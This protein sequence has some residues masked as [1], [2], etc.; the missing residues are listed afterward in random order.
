MSLF[1]TKPNTKTMPLQRNKAANQDLY[2]ARSPYKLELQLE[3]A[4]VDNDYDKLATSRNRSD[5]VSSPRQLSGEVQNYQIQLCELENE[6]G[7]L[8]DK[9]KELEMLVNENL[10]SMRDQE[11]QLAKKVLM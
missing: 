6:N 5:F 3:N 2:S 8:E 10:L 4:S 1:S 7:E 9:N 11:E